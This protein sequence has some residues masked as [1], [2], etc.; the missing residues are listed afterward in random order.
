MVALVAPGVVLE[1]PVPSGPPQL[2]RLVAAEVVSTLKL[3]SS[4]TTTCEPSVLVTCT[5]YAA[6]VA[7]P[8]VSVVARST[9]PPGTAATAAADAE[10]KS[11]PV[12]A[13]SL[14]P[15]DAD[16][17]GDELDEVL[18]EFVTLCVARWR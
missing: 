17:V 8:S 11:V 9:V 4:M 7:V 14:D 13:V 12:R 1:L 18:D 10:D 2:P 5:S 16:E 3:A 15:V 6:P